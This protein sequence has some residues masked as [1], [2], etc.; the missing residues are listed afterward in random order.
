MMDISSITGFVT[1]A[2]S[3][4]V[5]FGWIIFF[6][7]LFFIIIFTIKHILD[8]TVDLWKLPF[9]ILLD[10]IDIMAYSNPYL[11]IFASVGNL[12]VFWVLAKRGNHMSKVFG[13]VAA[14]ESLIGIWI[15]PQY[16]FMTNLLPLSTILMFVA[17]WSD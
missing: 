5:G 11:D 2:V 8:I 13:V 3:S 7:L 15:F 14:A 12:V 9:T 1:Q 4:E 6:V 16:A 17:I 10:A